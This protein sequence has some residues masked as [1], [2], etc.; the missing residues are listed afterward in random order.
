VAAVKA[1][2]AEIEEAHVSEGLASVQWPGRFQVLAPDLV[3]DGAHNPA[4]AA[5]LV[6]T[7]REQYPNEKASVLFASLEDKDTASVLRC[8]APIAAEVVLVPVNNPR[9][10]KLGQLRRIAESVFGGRVAPEILESP[11]LLSALQR[12]P[13]GRRLATGSLYLVGEVLALH[14]GIPREPAS[15]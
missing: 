1:M 4:A 3:L 6:E 7:W 9:S 5:T 8:L 10:C 15:H 11:D 13:R 12:V 14:A 2:G